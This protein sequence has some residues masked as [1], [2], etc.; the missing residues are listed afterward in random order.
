[1]VAGLHEGL[2]EWTAFYNNCRP[3]Q[4]LSHRTP[5]A[6]RRN[7][8]AVQAADVMDNARALPTAHSYNWSR[9][10]SLQRDIRR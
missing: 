5:I 1:M 6:V 3:Y 7:G 10:N 2:A 9:Q 8:A 4:A